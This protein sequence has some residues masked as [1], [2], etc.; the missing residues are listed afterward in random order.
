MIRTRYEAVVAALPEFHLTPGLALRRALAA[1]YGFGSLWADLRAAAVVAVVALPLNIALAIALG[2]EPKH[3]LYTAVIAGFVAPLLGGSKFQVTGPTAAFAVI[4]APVYLQHGL[5]GLALAAIMAGVILVLMGLLRLGRLV[6]FIPYPVT[7][8]FTAGIGVVIATLQVKDLFGLEVAPE[9]LRVGYVEK[10]M[11]LA[12]ALQQKFAGGALGPAAAADLAI[13]LITLALLVLAP[14]AR[15]LRRI[16]APLIALPVAAALAWAGPQFI[17]GFEPATIASRFGSAAAPHGIPASAPPFLLP[18]S[19]P[20]PGGQ[21]LVL[22]TAIV[23]DLIGAAFSIAM[24]GAIAS[25]LSAVVADG[26]SGK[27]HDPDTELIAQGAANIAAPFFG[28]FACSGAVARTIVNVRAGAVSPLAAALHA[29]LLLAG[30]GLLPPVL[31][32]IPMASMAALLLVV[33][34]GMVEPKH[35]VFLLRFAP[36]SDAFVLV[37]CFALT[38]FVDMTAAVVAGV[39]L[40]AILF[41][42]RMAEASRVRLVGAEHPAF[43]LPVPE[44]VL[45]YDVGGPLFFGAAHRA[46]AE[47]RRAGAAVRVV[48]LDM[49]DVPLIDATSLVNLD[50]AI[51][52]LAGRG[53]LTVLAGVAPEPAGVLKKAGWMDRRELAVVGTVEAAVEVARAYTEG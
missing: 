29:G 42:R 39:V 43:R 3:G 49:T 21:P 20:G 25:L 48:I 45:L 41:M 12:R 11:A 10:C 44:G 18:L 19:E 50:S 33:A 9:V 47:L 34:R 22:S 46:L 7:T 27:R 24:L 1:G 28:G 31:G 32:F 36:R 13:G 8:A 30:I 53:I 16:P 52:G 17:A 23:R 6:E 37:V 5:A 2:L 14:R 15:G 26:L 35:F 40:A 4:L 51:T 38:V